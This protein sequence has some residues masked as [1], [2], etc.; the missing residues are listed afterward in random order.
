MAQRETTETG[1]H[2]VDK[3][4]Q[5]ER[6]SSSSSSGLWPLWLAVALIVLSVLAGVGYYL[7][8][9]FS[10]K[11]KKFT[12]VKDKLGDA[13][14]K[15]I[16]SAAAA[17]GLVGAASSVGGAITGKITSVLDH[18]ASIIQ[19]G[20]GPFRVDWP[21]GR[22]PVPDEWPKPSWIPNTKH[23]VGVY[24]E[25][26]DKYAMFQF[27]DDL[28]IFPYEFKIRDSEFTTRTQWIELRERFVKIARL[29]GREQNH[30]QLNDAKYQPSRL[31]LLWG[32]RH[33]AVWW[34]Q[35]PKT[36]I[37]AVISDPE[38]KSFWIFYSEIPPIT[39]ETT[40]KP[41]A[42]NSHLAKF[43]ISF[44]RKGLTDARRPPNELV[45]PP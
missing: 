37:N 30:D 10:D 1:H 31:A 42:S 5:P 24:G 21:F 34:S 2:E 27:D 44:L 23:V 36:W 15:I 9:F 28:L 12:D 8:R 17:V 35:T 29:A 43:Y 14:D 6:R 39:D 25:I 32:F 20:G 13:V 11:L 3:T 7:Y 33:L 19:Y 18:I 45:P 22:K 26:S 16:D 40:Y 38:T 41:S 4:Q